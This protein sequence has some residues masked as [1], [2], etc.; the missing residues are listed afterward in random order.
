MNWN[1]AGKAL[2][3]YVEFK[4]G[5]EFVIPD[6]GSLKLTLRGNDG[7]VLVGY[8]ASALADTLLSTLV[9]VVPSDVNVV[10]TPPVETRFMRLDFTAGGQPLFIEQSYNLSPFLPLIATPSDVRA[11]FGA[12]VA[13]LPDS[14]I[15][16][17]G[18]YFTLLE[19]YHS[20]MSNALVQTTTRRLANTAVILK[21]AL[22]LGGS[23]PGRMLKEEALNN[24]SNLRGVIDWEALQRKN[25]AELAITLNKLEIAASATAV[26]LPS[27]LMAVSLPTDPVTN[28]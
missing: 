2:S 7:V 9:V 16:L 15:D 11:R 10:T 5:G 28:A 25:E 20:A 23:M 8:D 3:L 26:V 14:D 18:A 1:I 21:T 24:A 12:R 27:P 13:E 19:D 22:L 6:V 4:Q 17:I